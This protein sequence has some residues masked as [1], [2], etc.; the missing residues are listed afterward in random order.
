MLLGSAVVFSG[1]I[2]SPKLRALDICMFVYHFQQLLLVY[3][4]FRM[5]KRIRKC[6]SNYYFP[7]H[8]LILTCAITSFMWPTVGGGILRHRPYSQA[9][10]H[11]V[12]FTHSRD[13]SQISYRLENKRRDRLYGKPIADARVDMTDLADKVC[14]TDISRVAR[15]HLVLHTLAN[16]HLSLYRPLHFVTFPKTFSVSCKQT[17]T[18]RYMIRVPSSMLENIGLKLNAKNDIP[19]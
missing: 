16:Y 1:P 4:I 18:P 17:P 7:I 9:Y 6:V 15:N 5:Q 8:K 19:S 2:Y 12:H 3:L 13:T 10:P 14:R 11:A